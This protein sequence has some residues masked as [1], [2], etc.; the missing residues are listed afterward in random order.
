MKERRAGKPGESRAPPRREEKGKTESVR[1]RRCLLAVASSERAHLRVGRRRRVVQVPIHHALPPATARR[2]SRVRTRAN[3]WETF[4][5]ARS[6]RRDV[7]SLPR[8]SH[9][10]R[11]HS[12]RLPGGGAPV[13]RARRHRAD[14]RRRAREDAQK[15]NRFFVSRGA[16]ATTR[17][18]GARRALATFHQ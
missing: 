15:T 7:V 6:S 1:A 8:A 16:R 10:A 12:S 11:A 3:R 18:R 9:S 17:A 14:A 5:R 2:V 4:L 13:R